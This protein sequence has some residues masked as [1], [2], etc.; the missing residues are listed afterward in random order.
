[1]S[2]LKMLFKKY[3]GLFFLLA[4][5]GM[6]AVMVQVA[7]AIRLKH[8]KYLREHPEIKWKDGESITVY[9]NDEV[10]LTTPC[11]SCVF[12]DTDNKNM[13]RIEWH[14][15]CGFGQADEVTTI[16]METGTIYRAK[17]VPCKIKP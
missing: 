2:K 8:E 9:K 10:V 16:P 3:Y 5:I 15:E 7:D 11:G 12:A 1:M 17:K 14:R 6:V 4:A 13:M